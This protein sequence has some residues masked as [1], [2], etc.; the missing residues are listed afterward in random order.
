MQR[1]ATTGNSS[2]QQPI[3][4][5]FTPN[6][7]AQINV[8]STVEPGSSSQARLPYLAS[9]GFSLRGVLNEAFRHSRNRDLNHDISPVA[10]GQSPWDGPEPDRSLAG[11]LAPP[12]D[13]T[14]RPRFQMPRMDLYSIGA[15]SEEDVKDILQLWVLTFLRD[16]LIL[17]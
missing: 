16:L 10:A 1:N 9:E 6:P 12:G 5:D 7:N 2:H 14:R 4:L 17:L 13:A 3:Y 8:Q 11:S 15:I